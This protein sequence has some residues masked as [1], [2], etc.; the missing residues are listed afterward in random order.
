MHSYRE[1]TRADLPAIVAIYNA[2]IASRQVTADLEPVT[3]ASRE[4][5]FDDHTPQHRPLWVVER[6][7]GL[8]GW[9]SF[10]SF[11]GRPAYRHTAEL[12][13]YIRE[14]VRR[15]GLASYL[16][17]EA[18]AYAPRLEIDVLLGF[19]F[20]HNQPS[21][22]LFRRHGFVEWGLLPRVAVLDGIERDLAIVGRRVL[23]GR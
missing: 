15:A 4:R 10:S 7:D 1:A 22:E 21:L 3:V 6:D 8:I 17:R 14:D 12:S 20:A 5:W 11:Y 13:V 23:E 16:L 19:I 9:L 2:T 18:V